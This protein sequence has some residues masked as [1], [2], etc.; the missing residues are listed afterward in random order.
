MAEPLTLNGVGVG[1]AGALTG[2]G[3]ASIAGT[4][5]ANTATIGTTSAAS[6]LTLGGVV[7]A[8]TP[9][10]VVG[11][12]TLTATNAANN[13]ST[14]TATGAGNVSLRDTNAITL[15]ASTLSGALSVQAAGAV[16]VAGVVSSTA[17]GDAIVLSG[18]RFI[19]SV[20]ATALSA[21]NGRWLVW[22]SNASPFSGATPDNRNGLVYSFKQYGATYGVTPVAQSTGNGFLYALAPTVTPGLT[23][24]TS[25]V[26]DGT[27]AATLLPANF[28]A[29]GAVDGDTVSFTSTGATYVNR[30][31]G[32]GKS[33]TAT[34]LAAVASNGAATVYGYTPSSTSATASIGT[35]TPAALV[36]TAQADTR[37]YN[38]TTASSAAP[39]V[40]GTTYDAIGTAAIQTFDNRNA[41]TG[42][43]LTAGGLV[44]ADGNAGANYTVN[45]VNNTAGVITPASLTVTAQTD[46][47][48]YNGTTASRR[49][50]WS[51]GR[52]TTP[53]ACG[54]QKFDN[55][56]AGTGKTQAAGGLVMADG[57]AAPT[58]RSTTSTTPAA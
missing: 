26:Y 57:K 21:P 18:N 14:V 32:V 12:G 40:T 33:V 50:P 16:T 19:N 30:N 20:G 44:M 45:Y 3:T 43:I 38:G 9:L 25:K 31:V 6:S 10:T 5:T 56:N 1:G 28:T 41:G 52:P 17:T 49:R 7:T 35:I 15:N 54:T 46:T 23:G 2:T 53:S 48:V 8:A 4:V 11:T 34:G 36:V 42:K 22:S 39:V 55:R 37:V 29:V 58:T 13:F 24:T 51:P 27:T 47:R